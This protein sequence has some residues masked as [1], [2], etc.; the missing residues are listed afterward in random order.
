MCS[1]LFW[2]E[3]QKDV[4]AGVTFINSDPNMIQTF[5]KLF[6]HSFEVD[7]SKFHALV[8]LH[9][10]HDTKV[11]LEYWSKLT[12]IPLKQFWKPYLKPHTGKNKRIDYPGCISI[13]YLDSQFGKLL[14]M[15][16]IEFSKSYRGVR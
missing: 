13:R 8:H 7:E 11:Q 2:A 14:K 12:G 5:L 6:R 9:E 15:I 16:Y 10:Y 4:R 3:G 1:L